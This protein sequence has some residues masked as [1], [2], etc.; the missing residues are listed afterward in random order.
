VNR[1][2]GALLVWLAGAVAA[3][4]NSADPSVPDELLEAIARRGNA[5]DYPEGPY[6]TRQGDVLPDLCFEGWLS[7]RDAAFDPARASRVCLSDL[8]ATPSARVLLVNSGAV[9]CV[10]CRAEY[11]GSRDRPSLAERLAERSD[12]GLMVLGS[13]FETRDA[14]PPDLADAALWARTFEVDFPFVVDGAYSLG[15]SAIAP[16]NRVVDLETMEVVLALQ[17]DEPATLFAAIDALL[18]GE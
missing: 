18:G 16:E 8:R 11:G 3:G 14:R 1:A 6:G 4:C 9:W 17:G 15:T 2:K 12:R 13:L 10:A 7:P 5:S